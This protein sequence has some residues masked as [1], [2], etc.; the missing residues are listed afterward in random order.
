M[1]KIEKILDDREVKKFFSFHSNSV[2]YRLTMAF[3]L[4]FMGPLL[5]LVFLSVQTDLFG[6]NELVYSLVGLLISTLFGYIIM[7]QISNGISRVESRMAA[8][9]KAI[10]EVNKVGEDE[11]ENISAF[12]D[13]MSESIK[14]TGESL[15]RRIN[16]IHA[17]RELGGLDNF[18]VTARSFTLTALE[19]SMEVTQA[20]C[21]AIFFISGDSGICHLKRGQGVCFEKGQKF[22]FDSLPWK[23]TIQQNK[24]LFLPRCDGEQV[25]SF[26][27]SDCSSAAIIPFGRFAA[28]T[29]VAILAAPAGAQWDETTLEFLSSYFLSIG[30]ALKMQEVEN[31]K[32]QTAHELEVVLSIISI[33]SSN[34]KNGDLLEIIARKIEEIL[35]H[36]WI[37]LALN[38][39]SDKCL[40][41]SHSFSRHGADIRTGQQITG[42]RSLFQ[43]AMV[44]DKIIN[45]DNLVSSREYFEKR[46][47][48][49]LG[50]KSCIL[51]S[52]NS[53][54]RAMGSICLGSEKKSAFGVREKR[55]LSM[56]AMAVSIAIDQSRI[57]SRERAKRE[58]LE[59]FNKIGGALTSH[60]IRADK[61]LS[62]IL[63][64]LTDLVGAE[65]GSIML[66]E[67]DTLIIEAAVGEFSRELQKQ[68]FHFDHG[69]AGYVVATGEAA[70]VGD[71]RESPHFLSALD[72][73]TGFQTRSML[74]VPL[75]SGGRVIGVIELLNKVGAP[76][77]DDDMQAVKTVASSTAMA[78]ENTRLYSESKHIAKKEKFIRTI[79]QKYVPEEIVTKILE[80][81]DIDYMAVSERKIV[82]IFNVDIRGY[83]MMSKQASTE[84]V[85]QILNHFFRK[86]GNIVIKHKG[87]LDKFLG[88]G[89]LAIFGAPAS[90][91]NPALDA[92]LAA[93]EMVKAVEKLSILSLDRCGLPLKIGIS[94]NTGEAIVGNIGFSKKME[95]TVIGDVVNE[96]FRLQDFTRNKPNSILIG[97]T[98]YNQVKTVIRTRPFGV[99]KLDNSLVNVYEV[100]TDYMDEEP[101]APFLS[102]PHDMSNI[103]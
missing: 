96:T 50:L 94:I 52:L 76:F 29:A 90:T 64:R 13:I 101:V 6:T 83:T 45:I 59:I 93:Q 9:L 48:S 53:R 86:M 32:Q 65:A 26:F 88:D 103:H 80:R 85:V 34:P 22:S 62:Y 15:S 8:K 42:K 67:F 11:L 7:R 98:T 12:A 97:E 57:F 100:E 38:R 44:R 68:K 60:T 2:F 1:K 71:T 81:G 20:A 31:Q 23:R 82:T 28:N 43:L 56:I 69:V 17:L 10:T 74:C 21:G 5:G 70:V 40:Y 4:F 66:L 87:L 54:G 33:L 63:E 51:S 39:D 95:Y 91:A 102:M 18:Q 75:I 16:E 73:K 24:P 36:H 61:I 46:L 55:I 41:L 79:F 3:A 77:N 58:E 72:R 14:K 47:F 37:G 49:K 27:S 84:D 89:M 99:K 78:L 25:K 30:N 92:V 19:R 35:P